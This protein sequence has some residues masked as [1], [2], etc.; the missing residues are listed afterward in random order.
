MQIHTLLCVHHYLWSSNKLA[1]HIRVQMSLAGMHIYDDIETVYM[2]II[3]AEGQIIVI[4]FSVMSVK[5]QELQ[6]PF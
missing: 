1:L 4:N 5:C 3:P 2:S 6:T